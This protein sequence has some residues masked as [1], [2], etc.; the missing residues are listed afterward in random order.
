[1]NGTS[2]LDFITA[3][4]LAGG[5]ATRMNRIDKG[6]VELNQKPLIEYTIE[7]LFKQIQSIIINAN[8][9]IEIYK[10]Y[11]YPVIEDDLKDYSGPLSGIASCMKAVTTR[12]VITVPCDSPFIP[13][14]L[15]QRLYNSLIS[16]RSEISVVH[17]GERMQPVFS[18][19]KVSLLPSLLDYLASGERKI[20]LWFQ[21]HQ[22]TLCDFS[23][24]PDAFI[25]INTQ[26]E[27]D[28]IEKQLNS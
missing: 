9:N 17:D 1:M 5:Q 28:A 8:R 3:I 16:E 23:D 4:V 25:N 12:F 21:Q 6:L 19:M 26:E 24:K 22:L 10:Q 15:A 27:I 20:E 7:S 11:G 2:D 14:D 13:L 18:L